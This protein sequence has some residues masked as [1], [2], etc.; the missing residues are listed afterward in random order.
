MT[1]KWSLFLVHTYTTHLHCN[2]VKNHLCTL[3]ETFEEYF[4][5]LLTSSEDYQWVQNPFNT[6]KKPK[7]LIPIEY[8]Q[9]VELISDEQLKA[10]FEEV[11]LDLFWSEIL[12]EYPCLDKK[13][14]RKSI[15]FAP[16]YICQSGFSAYVSTKNKYRNRLDA[17]SDMIIQLSNIQ[18]N[19]QR[20]IQC[21]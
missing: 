12:Y 20:I 1:F 7:D 17:A 16:S 3:S 4:Q 15:P 10:Q 6:I 14:I 18:P 11:P 9:P 13:A 19:F 2:C 8:D 21:K 5:T